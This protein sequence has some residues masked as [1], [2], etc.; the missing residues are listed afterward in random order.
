MSPTPPLKLTPFQ[1]MLQI[2]AEHDADT[3]PTA[4]EWEEL[5][6]RLL[7]ST[8]GY[9][10]TYLITKVKPTGFEHDIQTRLQ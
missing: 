10:G 5:Y 4:N 2:I 3:P 6:N 1:L 9:V 7:C 8:C